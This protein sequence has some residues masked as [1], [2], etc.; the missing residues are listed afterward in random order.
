[1]LIVFNILSSYSVLNAVSSKSHFHI[2]TASP[3]DKIP[4]WGVGHMFMAALTGNHFDS[5][6]TDKKKCFPKYS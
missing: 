1:L 6:Q 4:V 3:A 5:K 2:K